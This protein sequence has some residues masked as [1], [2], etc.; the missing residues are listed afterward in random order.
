MQVSWFTCQKAKNH[1]EP[2]I[3]T[4]ARLTQDEEKKQVPHQ[5]YPNIK[6]IAI[7]SSNLHGGTSSHSE[8]WTNT[9]PDPVH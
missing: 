8:K 3:I 7:L 9:N 1:E 4:N 5:T 6:V 2:P